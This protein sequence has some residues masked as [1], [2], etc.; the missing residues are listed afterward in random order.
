[1]SSLQVHL[2][3]ISLLAATAAPY[4]KFLQSWLFSGL[5]Q[6]R[7]HE[8]GLRIDPRFFEALDGSYW[9]NAFTLVPVQGSNFL[10]DIQVEVHRVGKSIALLRRLAPQHYLAGR[11]RHLEPRIRLAV[12]VLEQEDLRKECTQYEDKMKGVAE[13]ES[14]TLAQRE[15]REERLK[16]KLKEELQRKHQKLKEER[17]LALEAARVGK[18]VRQREVRDQLEKQVEEVRVR[19]EKEALAVKE[20]H[21][22]ISKEAKR[23]EEAVKQ[24]E[25]EDRERVEEFYAKLER[26]AVQREKRA[27]WRLRR[28][29]PGLDSKRRDLHQQ[30]EQARKREMEKLSKCETDEQVVSLRTELS[31]MNDPG[32]LDNRVVKDLEGNVVKDL[33]SSTDFNSVDPAAESFNLPFPGCLLDDLKETHRISNL[34]SFTHQN[35][36]L[37]NVM[38][39]PPTGRGNTSQISQP[40]RTRQENRL[41]MLE[42][43]L[44][45]HFSEEDRVDSKAGVTIDTNGNPGDEVEGRRKPSSDISIERLLYPHRFQTESVKPEP[46]QQKTA[47][48][49]ASGNKP[50]PYTISFPSLKSSVLSEIGG[51]YKHT[52][53]AEGAAPAPLA[54]TLQSSILKPLRVQARLADSALL[55]HILVDCGLTRHLA[56]LRSFLFL[57]DGEFGRQLVLSLCHLGGALQRPG[58]VHPL[59]SPHLFQ[60]VK[61]D[62]FYQGC[63]T[64]SF[65]SLNGRSRPK[66]ALSY[67]PEQGSRLCCCRQSR[68]FGEAPHIQSRAV[69]LPQRPWH[70]WPLTHLPC[71]LA[72][73]YRAHSGDA[74]PI[75]SCFGFHA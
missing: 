8:F 71:S 23:M 57:G 52:V 46:R 35:P 36:D 29:E 59:C 28:G 37:P 24:R 68:P 50:P 26:E 9:N 63:S 39:S 72:S 7:E 6:G 38:P 55:T 56:A 66:N 14:V 13:E 5:A 12:T 44:G 43:S 48:V 64:A 1:M 21:N 22:R 34:Q 19:K 47:F 45:D 61:R 49:V 31:T 4:F 41:L 3:L 54:L 30:M 58:E 16:E 32:S 18:V 73:Q 20:E 15:E 62:I 42:G 74:C 70:P 60:I 51:A 65:P 27:D 17:D 40:V 2:L 69:F 75:L 33:N 10:A 25:A 67:L 53:P 11:Y